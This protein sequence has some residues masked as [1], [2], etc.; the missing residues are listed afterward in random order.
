MGRS[1]S[2]GA[3]GRLEHDEFDRGHN[4]VSGD[5][6]R[7]IFRRIKCMDTYIFIIEKY[8]L[9]TD[10]GIESEQTQLGL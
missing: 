4:W 9:V 6:F 3:E 1:A 5:R 7:D 10:A 2:C 8:N